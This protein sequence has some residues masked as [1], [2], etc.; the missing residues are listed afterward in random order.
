[1]TSYMYASTHSHSCLLSIFHSRRLIIQVCRLLLL[2]VYAEFQ[3]QKLSPESSGRSLWHSAHISHPPGILQACC[4]GTTMLPWGKSCLP[5][6]LS[7]AQLQTGSLAKRHMFCCKGKKLPLPAPRVM[8]SEE[9]WQSCLCVNGLQDLNESAFWYFFEVW[10]RNECLE[11]QLRS[12]S[13]MVFTRQGALTGWKSEPGF[14][15]WEEFS[16]VVLQCS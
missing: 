13:L 9:I 1:M 12:H 10:L 11:A 3:S 16:W 14:L 5:A 8:L 4:P 15:S 7:P 6:L 2:S